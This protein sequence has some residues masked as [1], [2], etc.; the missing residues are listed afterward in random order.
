MQKNL[1][2]YWINSVSAPGVLMPS[3]AIFL[4]KRIVFG[5]MKT[6]RAE[7]VVPM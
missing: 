5:G 4:N 2:L 3:N 6:L 7:T 1:I